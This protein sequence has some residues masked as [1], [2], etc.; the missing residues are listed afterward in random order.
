MKE[1]KK[2]T[3][4]K[5]TQKNVRLKRTMKNSFVCESVYASTYVY[6][7]KWEREKENA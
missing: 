4:K 2:V 6:M 5:S 1:N 7:Q 3:H